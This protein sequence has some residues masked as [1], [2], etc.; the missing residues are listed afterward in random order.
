MAMRIRQSFWSSL[1]RSEIKKV[2][3]SPRRRRARVFLLAAVLL[4]LLLSTASSSFAGSATWL[5][6]PHNGDWNNAANWTAGGPPNGSA[7]T[8]TFASS[9]IRGVSFSA[10]TQVNGIVFNAGARP[11]TITAGLPIFGWTLTVSGVGIANNS[12][13]T[14]NFVTGAFGILFNNSA[15]AGSL[16]AFSNDGLI[17][18]QSSATAGSG[19][20]TN[21]GSIFGGNGASTAF[22]DTSTAGNATFTNNGGGPSGNGGF[23]VFEG[24]STADNATFTN[25]GGGDDGTGGFTGFEGSSAA[26]SATFFDNGG[27]GGT[28]GAIFF[29]GVS[30]GG[31]ARVEVFGNG[32]SEPTNGHLDISF[33]DAPGV[34]IGSIEGNGAVF[35][36]ANRLTVGSNNLTTTFSGVI[37]DGGGGTGGSLTKM[38]NGKLTLS[39]ASTYTGG[40]TLTKG[41][42]LVTNTTGSGTGTGA[43]QVNKGTLGGTGIIT[44]AVTVGT[45][46]RSGAILLAGNN[47]TTP[48]IL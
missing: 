21:N 6:S 27:R 40:T 33:H 45:G 46:T 29:E 22:V 48:G 43:V 13:I 42:L 32:T 10:A 24:S 25:T 3:S 38:G 7:D 31:T 35:L 1:L 30:T 28:A 9:S 2:I 47:A 17:F 37:Q 14:Q 15:T 8:A 5:A 18:F 44:G 23:T 39:N 41:T 26:D 12:G 20:F 36:G 11:F 34:M 4:P 16:T 19:T